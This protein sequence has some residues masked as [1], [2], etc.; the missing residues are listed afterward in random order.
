MNL[1]NIEV[2]MTIRG[3][4]EHGGTVTFSPPYSKDTFNNRISLDKAIEYLTSIKNKNG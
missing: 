1:K 3:E 4:D 2:D